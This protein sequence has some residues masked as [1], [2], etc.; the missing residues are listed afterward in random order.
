MDEVDRQAI[1]KYD[2]ALKRSAELAAVLAHELDCPSC[3]TY[4]QVLADGRA[5]RRLAAEDLCGGGDGA[6]A[7]RRPTGVDAG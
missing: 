4:G 1:A 3:D 7:E 2:A 6:R 5:V